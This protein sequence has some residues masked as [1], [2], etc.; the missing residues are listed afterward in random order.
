MYPLI[1]IDV[2]KIEYNTRTMAETLGARGISVMAVTKGFCAK[3]EIAEAML[4]GGAQFIADS[5]IQNLRS[6][7]SLK[8]KKVLLRLPMK[9]EIEDVIRYADYS[10]NSELATLKLLGEAAIRSGKVHKVIIMVDLGDY[11]E[12]IRY[13]KVPDFCQE[14]IGIDGIEIVGFGVNLTCFGGVI[15]EHVTLKRLVEISDAMREKYGLNIEIVSGGSSSSVY[16]LGEKEGFPEGINNLRLGESILLGKETAFGRNLPELYQDSFILKAQIIELK[17]KPSV[18]HGKIG[19]DAF[20]NVPSY[21]DR[22]IIKRAIVAL[23]KQDVDPAGIYPLDPEVDIIG[24][25]SDHM[26]L[27]LSKASHPYR[28]GD[29]VRFGLKYG[30]LLSVMTSIYVEKVYLPGDPDTH[31][32][33]D[34]LSGKVVI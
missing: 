21:R 29:I 1:E 20:G 30:G 19:R 7:R 10:L 24:A 28:V 18:P 17:D 25:S 26:I 34:L 22:G 11:R 32:T 4:R 8:A 16:L 27:D 9:S 6:L 13:H 33:D 2:K 23:G 3:K 15:P 14:A 31:D 12:G 5:R